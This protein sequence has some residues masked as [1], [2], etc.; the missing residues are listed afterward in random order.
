ML[1][2]IAVCEMPEPAEAA[3]YICKQGFEHHVAMVRSHCAAVVNEAVTTYLGW[4]VYLH[5]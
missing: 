1:G 3:K 4:D 5:E 2:G